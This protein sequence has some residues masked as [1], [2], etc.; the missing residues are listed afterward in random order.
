MN[1]ATRRR[2]IQPSAS[3]SEFRKWVADVRSEG[4]ADARSAVRGSIS[5]HQ[6][7]I[8]SQTRRRAA[9]ELIAHH[10]HHLTIVAMYDARLLRLHERMVELVML[11]RTPR[12]GHR[13]SQ[14]VEDLVEITVREASHESRAVEVRLLIA[15]AVWVLRNERLPARAF[16]AQFQSSMPQPVRDFWEAYNAVDA[17][18][19]NRPQPSPKDYSLLQQVLPWFY[20][21]EDARDRGAMYLRHIPLSWRRTGHILGRSH[22]WAREAE[23]RAID[24]IVRRTDGDLRLVE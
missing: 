1:T 23:A 12:P 6:A 14:A 7:E 3:D 18:T 13:K 19:V 17:P 16:P 4:V 24:Q 15:K 8:S 22:S 9:A 10:E 2:E 21:V 5:Q 11:L 20:L